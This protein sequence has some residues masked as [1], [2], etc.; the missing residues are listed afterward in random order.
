MKKPSTLTERRQ[1]SQVDHPLHYG[2]ADNAFETIKVLEAWL[3]P[4]EYVGFLKGNAIKYLSRHRH[5][6]GAQDLEKKFVKRTGVHV[7]QMVKAV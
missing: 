2:G 3:T 6:G 5:K 4:E 7:G 1:A